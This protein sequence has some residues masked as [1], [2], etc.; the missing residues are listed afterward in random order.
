MKKI[1]VLLLAVL[2][3]GAAF[4]EPAVIQGITPIPL[5]GKT[6]TPGQSIITL[7]SGNIF[8]DRGVYI[9]TQIQTPIPVSLSAVVATEITPIAQMVMN[10]TAL[11]TV[12]P[13]TPNALV[14]SVA[15]KAIRIN[16]GFNIDLNC[17]FGAAGATPIPFTVPAGTEDFENFQQQDAQMS[18]GVSCIHP[19]AATPASGTLQVWGY[20]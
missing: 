7:E 2:L 6:P 17:T 5:L 11:P 10:P 16:N 18:S 15:L 4:A 13:G 8:A 1:L 14:N 9:D 20:K 19:G 12:F 3:P